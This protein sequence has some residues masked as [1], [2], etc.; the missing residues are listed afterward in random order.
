MALCGAKTRSGQPCKNRAM[1]NGR[2][3]MHGGKATDTHKGNQNARTHGLYANGLT[4]E[5]KQ[6]YHHVEIGSIDD[7]LRMAKIRLRRALI[8]EVGEQA[9]ELIER[10]ESPS[11]LGGLPDYDEMIKSETFRKRD[12]G[13]IVDRLMSRIESLE[14]TRLELLKASPKNDEPITKIQIE[15]V[16]GKNAA[17]PDDGAAG[18]VLSA[19]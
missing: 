10:Q 19:N 18:E 7:E 14:R 12:W 13:P 3:R 16:S 11:M 5:E 15:V 4:D 17:N 2:C 1:S 6:V 8:A 9:L